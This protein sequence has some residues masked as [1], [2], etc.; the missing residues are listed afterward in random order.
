MSLGSERFDDGQ[1][2]MRWE[3]KKSGG[4]KQSTCSAKTTQRH[5]ARALVTL[6]GGKQPKRLI[7][8]RLWCENA[9]GSPRWFPQHKILG[10]VPWIHIIRLLVDISKILPCGCRLST[11]D[12]PR[13]VNAHHGIRVLSVLE[14]AAARQ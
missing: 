10:K 4:S 9:V 5:K 14:L 11:P 8:S 1:R 2:K 7:P 3:K 13:L 6:G 12:V